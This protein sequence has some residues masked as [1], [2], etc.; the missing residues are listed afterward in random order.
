M[1]KLT[2]LQAGIVL[3]LDSLDSIDK[4][5]LQLAVRF[6]RDYNYMCIQ[7]RILAAKGMVSEKTSIAKKNKKFYEPTEQGLK[8]AREKL[9]I[10]T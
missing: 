5:T 6:D 7:L 9:G 2:E 1:K 8:Q 4:S 10:T 3:K